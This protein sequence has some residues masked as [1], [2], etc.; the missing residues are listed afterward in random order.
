M[1][2]ATWAGKDGHFWLFGGDGYD[3]FGYDGNLNDLW[4]FD[5]VTNQWTWRGG[6]SQLPFG[7]N[8]QAGWPGS[9]GA[10]GVEA[11]SNH[12]GGRQQSA[13]WTDQ[14]GRLWLF[15]GE[16][17][18]TVSG[19]TGNL[20]FNDLWVFDPSNAE[21]TWISGS[22]TAGTSQTGQ[23]GVYGTKGIPAKG[24]SPGSRLDA[25]SWVDQSGN[26]WLFGG[27]GFDSAGQ[28]AY[29]NDLWKFDPVNELW[30]WMSGVDATGIGVSGEPGVYGTLGVPGPANTPGGR[31]GAAS[32]V[33][34]NGNLWMFGGRGLSS[35]S[36]SDAS[37]NDLW[38]YSPSTGEWT[39]MGGTSNLSCAELCGTLGVYGTL[40]TPSAANFPG[41]R[42]HASHWTDRGGNFWLFGG[43]GFSSRGQLLHLADLWKFSTKSNQWT[44]MGGWSVG[45]SCAGG[46][47]A[48]DWPGI[49]GTLLN[50][51]I[52]N[53][54]GS[55]ERS[56]SWTDAQGNLWLFGGYAADITNII[57]P[58]NDV[59]NYQMG[60]ASP[61]VANP[62][63]FN[64][65]A[66]TYTASQ[67]VTFA[68]STNNA[69]FYF[70][71]DGTTPTTNSY[72]SSSVSVNSSETIKAI[73]V[74]PNFLNSPAASAT[75]VINLPAPDFTFNASPGTIT[76][77]P[78]GSGSVTLSVT[79][80]NGF[81]STVSFICS[82]LPKGASCAFNPSTVTPFMDSVAT[83]TLTIGETALASN[84]DTH[85]FWPGTIVISCVFALS[86]KK[87]CIRRNFRLLAVAIVALGGI[88]ACGGASGGAGA[89]GNGGP[90]QTP[91]T[92]SIT[93][94]SGSIQK[95]VSISLVVK[96]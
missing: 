83:T 26:L 4:E 55:R 84:M 30:T 6:N 73:A 5:P 96:Q 61:S 91:S 22:S 67:S 79:P 82:G 93:A 42:S 29:L 95:T 64:P 53:S 80:L 54:P 24:N 8:E 2:A 65:V 68:S 60:T 89:V 75:Y 21:W 52:S 14:A 86:W 44:W 11:P 43:E 16:G 87:G 78:G 32:W 9:Y 40:D 62:P 76:I 58:L 13:A 10:L 50:P 51:S 27:Y 36:S 71:L 49:Y 20:L 47:P 35:I 59:W 48:C 28:G 15:G 92:V 12:P 31:Q 46:S 90:S 72:V 7:Q 23:A 45:R 41:G 38:E 33:D 66:G 77:S 69:A 17:Y 56:S 37:L 19:L 94:T 74:V 25:V 88:A 18:G 1:S 34:N 39:W 70:T 63:T 81:N 85:P 57:A 3:S